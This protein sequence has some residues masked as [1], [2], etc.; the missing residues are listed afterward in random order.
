MV[1]EKLA[2]VQALATLFD[3]GTEDAQGRTYSQMRVASGLGSYCFGTISR[4]Y[5]MAR[6]VGQKYT[7]KWGRSTRCASVQVHHPSPKTNP[8]PK[9]NPNQ[10]PYL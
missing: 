3:V 7:V 10:E 6:N 8:N 2:R 9:P 1:Y 5:R 4:V